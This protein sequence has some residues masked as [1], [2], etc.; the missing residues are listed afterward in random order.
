M[1]MFISDIG[2]SFSLFVVSLSGFAI[3]V[4]VASSNELG[5]VLSSA[6]F[7]EEFQKDRC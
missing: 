1:S 6:I 4:M 7:L 2:L 3:R 5:S